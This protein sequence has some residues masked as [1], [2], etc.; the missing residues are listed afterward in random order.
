MKITD[1]ETTLISIPHLCGFQDA[2]V[3]HPEKGYSVCFV[4]ITTDSGHE[5]LAP[6]RGGM[7]TREL[8][9]GNLKKI[10]LGRDPLQTERLWDD[11]F[12]R[13][14]GVGRKGVAIAAIRDWW[15]KRIAC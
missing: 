1:I 3:R 12:W 13:L 4:H 2:T 8:V 15:W 7:L 14:R 5:G 11:M 9:E 10:L 6:G